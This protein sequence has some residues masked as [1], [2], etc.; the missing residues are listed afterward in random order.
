MRPHQPW[1]RKQTGCYYVEVAGR[2]INLG[3]D[4]KEAMKRFH[5]LMA[6]EVRV[7]SRITVD[8]LADLFLDWCGAENSPE[9]YEWYK[10]YLQNFAKT[11]GSLDVSSLKPFHVNGSAKRWSN[12]NTRRCAIVAIK[13]IVSWGLQEGYLTSDPLKTLKKPAATRSER[14]LTP[15][16]HKRFLRAIH[17]RPFKVFFFRDVGEWR[18]AWRSG[19]GLG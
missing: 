4:H 14:I 6:D 15:D 1:F 16:E 10:W 17:G 13:R 7:P 2:Q 5:R 19:S 18:R 11:H 8:T 12:P 9:T 3:K